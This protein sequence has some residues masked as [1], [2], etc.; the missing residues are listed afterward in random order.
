MTASRNIGSMSVRCMSGS[1]LLGCLLHA[2]PPAGSQGRV[3]DV[4][5]GRGIPGVR[6]TAFTGSNP[7]IALHTFTDSNGDF[8]FTEV[9]GGWKRCE[10]E[11]YK[12]L[13]ENEVVGAD[14]SRTETFNSGGVTG[15][16][17]LLILMMPEGYRPGL[18]KLGCIAFRDRRE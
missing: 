16:T 10:R 17:P 7:V 2:S 9:T 3:L 8:R 18:A 12:Q 15:T 1:L 14:G 4:I 5:T 6:V 13:S 11:G